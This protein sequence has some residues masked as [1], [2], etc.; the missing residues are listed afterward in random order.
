MD[1]FESEL[2]YENYQETYNMG[3]KYKLGKGDPH[4]PNKFEGK[5]LRRLMS[6]NNMTEDEVR[7]IKKY[8]KLLSEESKKGQESKGGFWK[9]GNEDEFWKR[10]TRKT[11]LVREHPVSKYFFNKSLSEWHNIYYKIRL[12]PFNLSKKDLEILEKYDLTKF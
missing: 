11:G 2:D 12:K 3:W 10:I 1:I 6:E 5:L 9:D 8:R 4:I 7:S